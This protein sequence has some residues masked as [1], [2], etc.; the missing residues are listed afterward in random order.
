VSKIN[1]LEQPLLSCAD[2]IRLDP[3][4]HVAPLGCLRQGVDGWDKP[5]KPGH[6]DTS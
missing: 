5:D 6:D 1:A 2:L 3:R 4:I